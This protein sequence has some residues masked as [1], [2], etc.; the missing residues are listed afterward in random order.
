M[1]LPG[2]LGQDAGDLGDLGELP[3]AE[4]VELAGLPLPPAV[5]LAR[6]PTLSLICAI[7]PTI[8]G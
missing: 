5:G 4:V 8:P 7:I 3:F 2:A 6:T 1:A